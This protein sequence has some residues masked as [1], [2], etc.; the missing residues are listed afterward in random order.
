M[1]K[2]LTGKNIID[3]YS[4]IDALEVKDEIGV[5][6]RSEK[7]KEMKKNYGDYIDSAQA[8]QSS[9]SS[10]NPEEARIWHSIIEIWM[11]L[12]KDSNE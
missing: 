5:F 1:T 10:L 9:L 4:K 3:L 12:N 11:R 6:L 2:D 7:G 8:F